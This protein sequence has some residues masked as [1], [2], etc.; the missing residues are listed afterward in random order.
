MIRD[1]LEETAGRSKKDI[2]L[3][4]SCSIMALGLAYAGTQHEEV[5]EELMTFVDDQSDNRRFVR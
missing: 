1:Y 2:E 4:R 5:T 3:L